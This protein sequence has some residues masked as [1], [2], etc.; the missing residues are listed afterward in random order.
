MGREAILPQVTG[1]YRMGDVRHC[2]ADISRAQLVLGYT[3]RHSFAYGL[4][5]LMK[6]LDGKL[7]TD[8]TLDARAELDS[9]GLTI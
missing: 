2:F 8:R 5:D 1:K 7:P 4:A 3:P 6:W 9:R